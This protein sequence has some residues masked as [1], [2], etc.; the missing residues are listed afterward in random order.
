MTKHRYSSSFFLASTL[1]LIVGASLF[2]LLNSATKIKPIQQEKVIKV[3]II[4]P[5]PKIV[6]IPKVLPTPPIII[7]QPVIKKVEPI[8]KK[9]P[10]KPKKIVQK[11]KPKPQKI[12]QKI[13]QKPQ[14]IL[15]QQPIIEYVT[16]Q[17]VVAVTKATK[18][19][20]QKVVTSTINLEGEKKAFLNQ[21]RTKI[22]NNKQYPKMALRR[23]IQGSVS[24]IFDIQSS[25]S[26][27]NIRF[28]SGK[29]ILQKAV[30]ESIQKSFPM[31]IPSK[32]STLFPIHDVTV[33]I[34]FE[35]E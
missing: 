32:L 23:H 21:V 31:A 29:T 19:M 35:I 1:Y 10:P 26:V 6:E 34:N 22:A 2:S 27:S 25:G 8:V 11:S 14:P 16:P 7:P 24:V 3:A 18:P 17:P 12:V 20:A 28:N 4:T 9:N 30:K 5:T 13:Q 15:T 33:S